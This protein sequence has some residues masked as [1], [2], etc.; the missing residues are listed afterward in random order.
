MVAIT[1]W[2]LTNFIGQV[3]TS[4][5]IERRNGELQAE[6]AKLEAEKFALEQEVAYAESPAYAEQVA[7]ERLGQAREG[8]TVIFPTFPDQPAAEAPAAPAPLPAPTA[9][10]NLQ[11]WKQALFPP[12]PTR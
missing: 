11:A 12:D 10:P 9:V 1:L 8:D 7:R 2:M 4:A 6:I 3:L 5:Q